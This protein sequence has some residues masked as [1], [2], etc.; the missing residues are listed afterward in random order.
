MRA[1]VFL[2]MYL[3]AMALADAAQAQTPP[4]KPGLWQMQ[5]T[6]EVDG[7]KAPDPLEHL[8]GMPPESRKRMEEIMRQQGV[9]I[10]GGGTKMCLNRDSLDQGTWQ[11]TQSG[12]KTDFKTRSSSR[13]AW[14]S[15]CTQP[16]SES[17]GE[18]VFADSEN[19]TVKHASTMTLQG[20]TQV[21]QMT[22]TAK[23]LGTD[24]GTLKPVGPPKLPVP[25]KTPAQ[26]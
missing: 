23:W 17:D 10:S 14:H 26:K 13:W 24:C 6:R 25:P 21:S 2:S 9:D 16:P 22:I 12:C 11:G 7:K 4:V 1:V 18:A 20:Q 3:C 8:K 15:S 5:S 19:Y